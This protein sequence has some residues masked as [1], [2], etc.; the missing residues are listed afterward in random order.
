MCADHLPD[1]SIN[2]TSSDHVL[3]TRLIAASHIEDSTELICSMSFT[4]TTSYQSVSP[5][6]IHIEPVK[7]VY[8]FV[9]NSPA[10]RVVDVSG[11]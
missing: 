1:T 5:R 8:Q 7:P 11:M 4:L 3:Y 9:W 6:G 2:Q 10:I